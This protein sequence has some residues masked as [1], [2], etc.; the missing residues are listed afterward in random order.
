MTVMKK[1][2]R[3]RVVAGIIGKDGKVLIAK[4]RAGDKLG[5]KWEF[6]GGKVDEGETPEEALKR[7]LLEELGIETETGRFLCS[8]FY[9]YSH[10]SVEL[11]AYHVRHVSGEVIPHVHDEIRW[12]RP[13]KLSGY[14][15]PEANI[16]VIKAILDEA[17]RSL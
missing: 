1:Q 12:V 4:R 5:G 10:L 16:P 9:D 8:S 7:E 6:P 3:V 14:E 17:G 13:E 2:T 15:F 11:L